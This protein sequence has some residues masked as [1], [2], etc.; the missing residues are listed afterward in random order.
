MQERSRMSKKA[1][2]VLS[3]GMDSSTLLHY[4]VKELGF[5]DVYAITF[6]YGQRHA[7]EIVLAKKQA[8]SMGVTD[9]L[10]IDMAFLGNMV[11]HVSSLL[12]ESTLNVPRIT[13]VLGD[14]SPSTEVPYRNMLFISLAFSYAQSI[15]A[16][17]VFYGIHLEDEYSYWDTTMKFIDR[18]NSVSKLN[19]MHQ[20]KA[21]APF[22]EKHKS[23]IVKIGLSLGV[24]FSLT[25]SCYK[26]GDKPC[27]HPDLCPTCAM[28]IKAFAANGVADPLDYGNVDW[29]SLIEKFYHA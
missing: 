25:T 26:G 11:K 9:H 17:D 15:R 10:F 6:K 22:G 27:Q 3:G 23:D 7:K 19:R 12:E 4:V 16:K 29:N 5:R 14:P 20:I 28:R 21:V 18:V 8:I 2:V 24:D 13:D 1:V